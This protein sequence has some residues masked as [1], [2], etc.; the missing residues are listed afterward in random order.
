MTASPLTALHAFVSLT[1]R[2]PI[3]VATIL[4]QLSEHPA[5]I[6]Y[7]LLYALFQKGYW[8]LCSCLN[9]KLAFKAMYGKLRW[10][11]KS[12]LRLHLYC[13]LD[14]K[15]IEYNESMNLCEE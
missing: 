14:V 11:M 10:C 1:N 8:V 7:L 2:E 6:K 15:Q 3:S 9:D 12:M 4:N 13:L 5:G